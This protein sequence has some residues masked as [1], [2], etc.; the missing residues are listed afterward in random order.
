M[1]SNNSSNR[2]TGVTRRDIFDLLASGKQEEI[3]GV[4]VYHRFNFWGRLT[5]P[6]FLGRLYDLKSLPAYDSRC[7][8][9]EE[10]ITRHTV[11][12]LDDYP[13]DWLFKDERFPLKGGLIRIYWTL[14]VKYSILKCE[15]KIRNGNILKIE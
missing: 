2:I 6:E 11:A 14:F 3:F 5:P 7:K 9:A 12:N 13:E 15:M 10:D 8:N 1:R 4:T